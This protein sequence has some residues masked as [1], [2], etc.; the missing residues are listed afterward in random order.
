MLNEK[1][2]SENSN[3]HQLTCVLHISPSQHSGY[4]QSLK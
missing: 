1:E 3:C 4:L 2:H